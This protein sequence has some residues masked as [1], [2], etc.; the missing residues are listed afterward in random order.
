MIETG[1]TETYTMWQKV[2]GY[3]TTAPLCGRAAQVI[4]FLI[5]FTIMAM[6][7]NDNYIFFKYDKQYL[8]ISVG[9][10]QYV[11]HEN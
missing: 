6:K 9:L 1:K 8:F 10:S 2:C 5:T 3:L 7:K 4:V 11:A